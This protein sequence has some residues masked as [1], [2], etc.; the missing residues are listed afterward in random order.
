MKTAALCIVTLALGATTFAQAVAP[1][2]AAR[3]KPSREELLA[4]RYK[5]TGGFIVK[6]GSQKGR[7]AIF[8]AQKRISN[9][10]LAGCV[11]KIVR[12]MNY[13]AT[14]EDAAPV[15]PATAGKAKADAKAS[16]AVFIVDDPTLPPSLVAYEEHWGIVNVAKLAE[17]VDKVKL[18]GRAN[19]ETMRVIALASGAGDSQFPGSL[20]HLSGNLSEL[21]GVDA[22][23]PFDVMNRMA[24]TFKSIGM[25]PELRTTYRIACKEG[26]APAPTN[27]V[28]KFIWDKVHA[29][30]KNPMKIEFDPKKGK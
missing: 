21:D 3:P 27:E 22:E 29:L 8:N 14:I 24:A 2:D 15:T 20:M 16:V 19:G 9:A 23:L 25:T 26:W 18:F 4:R 28:Q 13:K 1:A 6:P 11:D 5:H 12:K 30:P 17:G 7:V 10:E